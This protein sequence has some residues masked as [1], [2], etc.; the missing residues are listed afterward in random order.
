MPVSARTTPQQMMMLICPAP[1]I[2]L[3]R[4][5]L[6]F[7]CEDTSPLSTSNLKCPDDNCLRCPPKDLG[8]RC[9]IAG[10]QCVSCPRGHTC[11]LARSPG[12]PGPCKGRNVCD[13]CV[14][15]TEV[16]GMAGMT[17]RKAEA[18]GTCQQ[19]QGEPSLTCVQGYDCKLSHREM[20]R[21]TDNLILFDKIVVCIDCDDTTPYDKSNF[22]CPRD[23]CLQCPVNKCGKHENSK[24]NCKQHKDVCA[25]CPRGHVCGE[26]ATFSVISS[27]P[28]VAGP[29]QGLSLIHI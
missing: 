28:I 27:V 22:K 7:D 6:C 12:K 21:S 2:L 26:A 16:E 10:K 17:V 23:N 15:Y 11:G 13:K 24:C 9:M 18:V 8:R 4:V 29:C 1:G 5:A 14:A 19:L 3:A 25:S 20:C